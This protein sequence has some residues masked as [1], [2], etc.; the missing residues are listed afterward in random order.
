[1]LYLATLCATLLAI[2]SWNPLVLVENQLAFRDRLGIPEHDCELCYRVSSAMFVLYGQRTYWDNI[3]M[4]TGR[5]YAVVL[6]LWGASVMRLFTLSH[7]Y[8]IY[9]HQE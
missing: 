5:E 2:Q 7:A 9:V 8:V 4:T 6:H 1:M 3:T